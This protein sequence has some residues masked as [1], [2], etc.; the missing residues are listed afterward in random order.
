MF[1]LLF[2][3]GLAFATQ[4]LN[5]SPTTI[6]ENIKIDQFGY[7]PSDTKVAVIAQPQSGA[8]SP[9]SYTPAATFKVK[10]WS[11]DVEVFSAS[12][13]AWNSGATHGQSGDKV[14]WFDFSSLTTSGDYYVYDPTNNVGSYR[15]TINNNIFT[16][17]LQAASK[18]FFYQRCGTAITGTHGGAWTHTACHVGAS[19]DLACRSVTD[20]S[21]AATE[22]NLSG[23]WHDAGDYNKYV[24]FTYTPLHNLLF[25]Y[26]ETPSVFGDNF[27]IPESGDGVPDI[28]NEVKWELDWLLKMQQSDGSVLSKVSVT[29]FQSASPPNSDAAAHYYGAVSTS[30]TLTVASVFAH[31]YLIFKD[32]PSLSAYATTLKTKAELAWTWAAA[33]GSVTYPNTGFSSAG[34]EVSTYDVEARK[35]CAAA[36]LYAATG[37]ASYKTYF[38]ANYS[39]LHP[40]AWYY[41]YTFEGTYGDIALYY[42]TLSGGDAAVKSNILSRFNSSTNGNGDF[43]PNFTSQTDAYRAYMK[44]N[45]YVWGNNLH[46]SLLGVM[47][48]GM[49]KYNQTPANHANYRTQA[50]DYLHFMHGVNPLSYTMLSN[51][52][53]IGA[54]KST[55]EIYHAWTGDGT[56]FDQNPI[57]G[58]LTG[59]Y[60]KNYGG[61]NSYFT[62]QPV[63]KKYKN[64]N[65]SY[66]ENSW[67]ITEPAIYYQAAYIRLV[68]KYATTNTTLPLSLLNFEAKALDN[69]HVK[70]NWQTSDEKNVA[71]FE[72]ER[73]LDGKIFET[74]GTVKAKNALQNVYDFTDDLTKKDPSVKTPFS[75]LFYRLKS[76]NSDATTEFSPI[77][78]V[79]FNA[80][81]RVFSIFPNPTNSDL[82][83]QTMDY[84]GSVLIEIFNVSG[85]KMKEEQRQ[86][87]D[88]QSIIVFTTTDLPNGLY[89]M[90][91]TNSGFAAS[92]TFEVRR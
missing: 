90:R 77:R 32:I 29:S 20:Q 4:M 18:A 69:Q 83:V 21:N 48:E 68:A 12:T 82:T 49:I 24:N 58:L 71:Q 35:T 27:G 81:K 72:I 8:G 2:S 30:S 57:P 52:A 9:S 17:P 46:K 39:N 87:I 50:L 10:R 86:V 47:Y 85:Q 79:E 42:T 73:S 16:S 34:T 41:F 60:N 88:N 59:G 67:E 51:V 36:L 1:K 63:L 7:R 31:A 54:E 38:D 91:L 33:N 25:A 23:G 45:D 62:G 66:P 61:T 76:V 53:S 92:K 26:Q 75:T 14:W 40:Y 22:K 19:Q 84:K 56:S 28:L 80:S 65:T 43:Y 74:L 37:T 5:A 15:F 70:L 64:W 55:T 11:D 6:S 78:A 89:S 44:D 13:T 3:I